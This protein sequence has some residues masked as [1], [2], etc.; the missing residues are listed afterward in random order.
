MKHG[1]DADT[2]AQV[3]WVGCDGQHGLGRRLEQQVV[4]QRL[5]VEG[6]VG[7]LGG[8]CEDHLE[9]PDRQEVGL[10][11]VEP[12]ACCGALA[13]WAVPVAAG[14]I[15]DPLMPAV[16]TGFD[17]TAQSRGAASLDR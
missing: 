17:V 16:G 1:G 9:V 11:G 2:D 15:G 12:C 6:N 8:Q 7:D 4:D 14:V 13:P 3:L 5:V 10:L